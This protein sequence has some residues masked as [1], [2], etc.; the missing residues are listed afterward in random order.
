MEGLVVVET[1]TV[2]PC[3]YGEYFTNMW[4]RGAPFVVCEWD[5]VPWPGAITRLL[6]CSE[7]WCTH[8]YPVG[9][10]VTTSFGIGKY[11]PSGPAAEEWARTPWHL[12]DGLV[13]PVLRARLGEPHIHEPPVAHVRREP[14]GAPT[15]ARPG[16]FAAASGA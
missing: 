9:G 14:D 13:V 15:H 1:L 10:N 7:P 8:R 2:E 4:A 11:R 16:G 12:L 3:D 6:E 5:I